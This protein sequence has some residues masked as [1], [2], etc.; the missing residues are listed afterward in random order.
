MANYVKI[1]LR[2]A[3]RVIAAIT[4]SKGYI[5]LSPFDP[6]LKGKTLNAGECWTAPD[7]L[8]CVFQCAWKIP[9]T[10]LKALSKLF[11]TEVISITYADEDIGNSCGTV[12][13]HQGR[14]VATN[15]R[16]I[17]G[18]CGDAE[19]AKWRDFAKA[20]WLIPH[21]PRMPWLEEEAA[22]DEEEA[23]EDEEEST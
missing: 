7:G 11:A 18:T 17:G 15:W 19:D 9:D 14:V 6:E 1:D 4:D 21:G 2:A 16:D 23:A 20:V 13:Y 3:K 8:R 12:T 5:D 22:E 10:A